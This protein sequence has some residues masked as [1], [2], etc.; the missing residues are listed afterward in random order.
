MERE[1]IESSK[2]ERR[3]IAK[4]RGKRAIKLEL[5]ETWKDDDSIS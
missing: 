5:R 4:R 1:A 2:Q 3:A